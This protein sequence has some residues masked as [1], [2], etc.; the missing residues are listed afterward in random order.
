MRELYDAIYSFQNGR[1]P[2]LDGIPV[3]VYRTLFVEIKEALLA[4]F[5]F[6]FEVG[7]QSNPQK[8]DL[9][10]LLLKHDADPVKQLETPDTFVL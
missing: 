3:E 2:R 5:D 9:I 6:S 1:S 10:S 7:Q 8:E 4:C